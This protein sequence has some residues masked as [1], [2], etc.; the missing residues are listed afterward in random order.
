ME[1]NNPF[2]KEKLELRTISEDDVKKHLS[3]NIPEFKVIDL[4]EA[5]KSDNYT[6]KERKDLESISKML[7]ANNSAIARNIA[8]LVFSHIVY[9]REIESFVNGEQLKKVNQISNIVAKHQGEYFSR[10][11]EECNDYFN[12]SVDLKLK[13]FLEDFNLRKRE[14]ENFINSFKEL[15]SSI[16]QSIIVYKELVESA[17]NNNEE[18]KT[19]LNTASLNVE[20]LTQNLDQKIEDSISNAFNKNAYDYLN[21]QIE[22]LD[23]HVDNKIESKTKELEEEYTKGK[24]LIDTARSDLSTE[25]KKMES[26]IAKIPD[27]INNSVNNSIEQ[28]NKV[29]TNNLNNTVPV[30]VKK[31]IEGKQEIIDQ[32][33]KD[34]QTIVANLETKINILNKQNEER[35]KENKKLIKFIISLLLAQPLLLWLVLYFRH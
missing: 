12:S 8:S 23:E 35:V 22:A 29:T 25:I 32:P 10:L 31:E 1:N 4:D 24:T 7:G 13:D 6:E 11:A 16:D 28:I 27:T 9:F 5:I 18:L 34:I 17:K 3:L 19:I 15:K 30:I 2:K 21:P 33:K 20:N 14:F 26:H